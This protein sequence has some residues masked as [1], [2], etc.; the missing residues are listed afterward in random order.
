M[1]IENNTVAGYFERILPPIS[2]QKF[3]LI[4][5]RVVNPCKVFVLVFPDKWAPEMPVLMPGL[6]LTSADQSEASSGASDQ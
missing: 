4:K 5:K 3:K 6:A 2:L 1:R